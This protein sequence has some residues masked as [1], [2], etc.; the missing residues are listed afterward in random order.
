MKFAPTTSHLFRLG[1]LLL[2]TFVV[3]TSVVGEAHASNGK[4]QRLKPLLQTE[5]QPDATR[6][7][8]LYAQRCANCHGPQGGGDG[9]LAADLPTPPTPFNAADYRQTAV[10]LELFAAITNGRPA[11]GM[12]PFGPSSSNPIDDGGRWDLVAAIYNL[13]TPPEAIA[14][15]QSVYEATCLACHG[16]EGAGDGPEAEILDVI[17]TNISSL[18][19]W[20]SRS[21]AAVFERLSANAIPQHTYSLTEEQRRTVV[22]YA[23]TFSYTYVDRQQLREPIP[24]ATISGQVVNGTTNELLDGGEVLLRAF[25]PEL[26]E[27]LSLTTTTDGNGRYTFELTDVSPQWIF[28]ASLLY[29]D[30]SFSSGAN[31]PSRGQPLLELPI[32][33]YEPTTNATA[34]TIEQLHLVLEFV[35]DRLLVN[36]LY[37][38]S[39]GDTAVYIGPTGNTAAGTVEVVLPAGAQNIVFQRS[40]G[41][42]ESFLPAE[43][44]VQTETGWADTVPLRPGRGSLNLLVQYELPYQPGATTIAHPLRYPVNE[45]SAVLPDSGV[46]LAGSNWVLQGIQETEQ[47]PYGSYIGT[48]LS[49]GE[50]FNLGLEGRPRLVFDADGNLVLSRNQ[51]LELLLGGLILLGVLAGAFVAVRTWQQPAA[52]PAPIMSAQSDVVELDRLLQVAADLDEAYEQGELDAQEYRQERAAVKEKLLLLWPRD[53]Q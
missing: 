11:Q 16:A 6:G 10:P 40:L 41:S 23:R 51:P 48:G 34:I 52:V 38:F 18:D 35:E 32:I 28:L 3:T 50:T 39:N 22:D 42:L 19:Y 47:G 53:N 29:E 21:N 8:E 36:E 4:S 30:V 1:L 43:E 26:E 45:T 33:V 27:M 37:R 5:E 15:G 13:S 12:P 20:A 25:T 46:T 44:V 17:P 9:E 31:Q 7:L 24:A 14:T 49:A 2:I